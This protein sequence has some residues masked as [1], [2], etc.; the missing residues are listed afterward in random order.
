M[1]AL[2]AATAWVVLL[3]LYRRRV[4]FKVSYGIRGRAADGLAVRP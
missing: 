3:W 2:F 1:A 4:F